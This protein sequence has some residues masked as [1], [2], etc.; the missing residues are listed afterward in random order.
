MMATAGAIKLTDEQQSAVETLV[1]CERD[2]QTLGG[3]AGCGKTTVIKELVNRLPGFAVCAYTGKA[4]DVL[5]RKGVPATTIHSLI[6]R[7]VPDEDGNVTFE[8]RSPWEFEPR[9]IIV[10]EAS[11]VPKPIYDD[12]LRYDAP[13][14][15]VGDHGQ[16][17]PV[18]G[19]DFN[20]MASPQVTLTTIHRNAGEIARFAEHL[21]EGG[22][23]QSWVDVELDR[24]YDPQIN[25]VTPD[26]LGSISGIDENCQ[27]ICAYNRTRTSLNA[28]VRKQLGFPDGK[29]CAGDRVI[30]L[31]NS[32]EHGVFNGMQGNIARID[33]RTLTL[34]LGEMSNGER[35][36]IAMPY[37]PSAF[38]SETKPE[39]SRDA[40][41]FDWA[42]CVTAHKAQGDEWGHV[43]AVEQRCQHW[44]HRRWSYTVAS[45]AKLRLTW[46]LEE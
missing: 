27:L 32:R 6:Y 5:R 10:D 46:V 37:V 26:Q 12:L 9:G 44:D 20:L 18:G 13:L 29:P 19:G 16:L 40:V 42:Y 3:Y 22:T 2:V 23:A 28:M 41:P 7:A 31:Q 39:Y 38:G 36:W 21:R 43:V 24:T 30:C 45:R 1:R 15:F 8:Q 35:H 4:A 14:I 17:E 11:M 34:D 33:R 25:I